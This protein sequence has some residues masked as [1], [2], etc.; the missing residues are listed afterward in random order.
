M[1][2]IARISVLEAYGTNCDFYT[3]EASASN[4]QEPF[5]P[6]STPTIETATLYDYGTGTTYTA[7]ILL[8]AD[9]PTTAAARAESY[10][11]K[12]GVLLNDDYSVNY[13]KVCVFFSKSGYWACSFTL[14]F[15]TVNGWVKSGPTGSATGDDFDEGQ[16]LAYFVQPAPYVSFTAYLFYIR[17]SVASGEK[18]T[19][20]IDNSAGGTD[21]TATITT[22]LDVITPQMVAAGESVS[23]EL[24]SGDTVAL[25]CA[26]IYGYESTFS[27]Y[28]S[29]TTAL[30]S[31]AAYSFVVTAESTITVKWTENY[32]NTITSPTVGDLTL[33]FTAQWVGSDGVTYTHAE[34]V[35]PGES[36]TL[37]NPTNSGVLLLAYSGGTD[38]AGLDCWTEDG[39]KLAEYYKT[40]VNI[41]G[42]SGVTFSAAVG[43]YVS[44]AFKVPFSGC[45]I[46]YTIGQNGSTIRSGTCT[47]TSAQ[48]VGTTIY[49]VVG[50]NGTEYK[51]VTLVLE[52]TFPDG[53]KFTGWTRDGSVIDRYSNPGTFS[54]PTGDSLW[55]FTAK[56]TATTIGGTGLIC[57]D[58][59]ELL[60]ADPLPET[61][62]SVTLKMTFS[63]GTHNITWTI[64]D[65]SG[66]EKSTTSI[67]KTVSVTAG[68][69]GS[70]SGALLY[71]DGVI[72]DSDG[73]TV[74]I[75]GHCQNSAHNYDVSVSVDGSVIYTESDLSGTFNK[76]IPLT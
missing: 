13:D 14:T 47:S 33:T 19:I 64:G 68:G 24:L 30:S 29:G 43:Y 26:N 75:S 17:Y 50:L 41:G 46:T 44:P 23:L 25:N 36:G 53:Y 69:S 38:T 52:A 39:E 66:T 5:S 34:T 51:N 70:D 71:A 73:P 18:Y 55:S 7:N 10:Y 6:Y 15:A 72:D 3:V 27:G 8:L 63:S 35:A 58:S 61:T 1:A 76:T 20:T 48:K 28:Y 37:Y 65:E 9:I 59:G 16:Y 57:N 42:T 49:R 40:S 11:T 45:K 31:L 32:K 62:H 56:E 60:Y 4:A 74:S 21:V 22:A 2:E 12:V 67:S 54:C